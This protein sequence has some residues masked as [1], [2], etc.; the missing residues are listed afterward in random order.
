MRMIGGWPLVMVLTTF[1][2]AK[3]GLLR[4]RATPKTVH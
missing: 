2:L 1:L 3:S 4:E